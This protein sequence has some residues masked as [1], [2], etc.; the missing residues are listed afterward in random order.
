MVRFW[1]ASL[2]ATTFR[3]SPDDAFLL[4]S[5]F[6]LLGATAG[7][8]G[9]QAL[10]VLARTWHI[11]SV[12]PAASAIA[13]IGGA[14]LLGAFWFS[15]AGVG[16]GRDATVLTPVRRRILI[17]VLLVFPMIAG[18][19]LAIISRLITVSPELLRKM[20][21]PGVLGFGLVA[22]GVAAVMLVEMLRIT[23]PRTYGWSDRQHFAAIGVV[24]AL[25]FAGS[26]LLLRQ[27]WARLTWP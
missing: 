11:W 7:A 20:T 24:W 3:K 1:E 13:S 9:A 10:I 27:A 12:P 19:S 18:I 23:F 2:S 25:C 17:V 26:A 5:V 16:P 8:V 21:F 15:L 22:H 14:G 6:V 4:R